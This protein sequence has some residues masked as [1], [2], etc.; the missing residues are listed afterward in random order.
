MKI[1]MIGDYSGLHACLAGELRRRG[2]SVTVVSDRGGYMQTGADI[3]LE[4]RPGTIGKAA[5]LTRIA[6]LLPRLKG[7]DVVQLINSNFLH[8]RPHRISWVYDYLRHNNGRIFLTL[9]GNDYY[10][11][12]ACADAKMFRFSEFKVGDTPTEFLHSNSRFMSDWIS[13]ENREWSQRLYEDIDGAMSVLPEYDMAARHILGDRLKFTNLPV[14]ISQLPWSPLPIRGKIRLFVGIRSGME[15]RK[16][17]LPLLEMAKRIQADY[18]DKVTVECVRDL[19]LSSYLE[20]MKSCH[21]VLDQLYSYS[22]ATNALQAMALGKIAASGAQP[23]YFT[24]LGGRG[25]PTP[26][27]PD[28]PVIC[29]APDDM[30]G[31]ESRIR[32]LIENPEK[33][34]PLSVAGRRLVEHENDVRIV[35]DRFLTHWPTSKA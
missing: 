11:V 21:I 16:G 32:N 12:K 17:T 5:Y 6:Y 4:R 15:I 25:V 26:Q 10:F 28:G 1:L 34:L 7:Y 33:M 19:S 2:H 35:A 20:R 23:E 24:S 18:P 30:S 31:N 27:S 29:L 14:D 22:P 3:Y 13:N 8:L 9:A